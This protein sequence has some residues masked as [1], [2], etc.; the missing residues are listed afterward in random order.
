MKL[1]YLNIRQLTLLIL[2]G[3]TIFSCTKAPQ[4]FKDKENKED[5]K[6]VSQ[7]IFGNTEFKLNKTDS[8]YLNALKEYSQSNKKSTTQS[9]I[10]PPA[11]TCASTANQN[12]Y[13]YYYDNENVIVEGAYISASSVTYENIAAECFA[14]QN[15]V[16]NA[17]S[18]LV[19]SGYHDIVFQIEE[20]D[21]T[22]AGFKITHAAN[23]L[24]WLRDQMGYVAERG[25]QERAVNCVLQAIGYAAIAELSANWAT[26]SRQYLIKAIGKLASRYLG[27]FGAAIA[28]GSFI[29]C[30]WG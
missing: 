28:L 16:T 23:S 22:N 24:I 12:T 3:L 21:P 13:G 9:V 6:A 17:R 1:N 18:Y 4:D 10:N 5:L 29:D 25:S 8:I 30:M 11:S 27:W 7:K 14:S 20:E 15:I 2:F 19:S 26:A